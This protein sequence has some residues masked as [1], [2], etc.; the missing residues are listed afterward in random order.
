MDT[1]HLSFWTTGVFGSTTVLNCPVMLPILLKDSGTAL[2]QLSILVILHGPA[3]GHVMRTWCQQMAFS[4][5]HQWTELQQLWFGA[6]CDC[7]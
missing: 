1:M 6:L 4:S 3:I 5:G 7:I 2:F